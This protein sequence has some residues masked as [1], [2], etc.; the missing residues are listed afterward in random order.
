MNTRT[1][2]RRP[3]R[4]PLRRLPCSGLFAA[5]AAIA[6][7]LALLQPAI[8]QDP[9]PAAPVTPPPT[10]APATA[11]L[12]PKAVAIAFA[13]AVDKGDAPTARSLL[14]PD[15]DQ[16]DSGGVRARWVDATVAL[17]TALHKLDAGAVARFGEPGKSVSQDQLHLGSSLKSIEQAQERID[18]DG[19]SATLTLPGQPRPLL[20]LRK[21]D[22]Q[23]RL[24]AGPR[25]ADAAD[26]LA[27][28]ARLLQAVTRTTDEIAAGLHPSAESAAHVFA[29]RLLEARLKR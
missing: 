14:L 12:S 5:L 28:Y 11:P 7:L 23:W 8:A 9:K 17:V 22:G 2:I 1:M 27:L 6:L 4:N 20:Q 26:Q 21:V 24:L 13:A 16:D 10:T 15:T 3:P 29:T 18:P 19:D 25:A